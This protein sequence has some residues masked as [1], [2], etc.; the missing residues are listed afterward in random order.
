MTFLTI[1][2]LRF[3]VVARSG[4]RLDGYQAGERLRDAF[5]Q[6]MLQTVCP[7]THPARLPSPEHAA[8]CPVCWLLAYHGQSETYKTDHQNLEDIAGEVRR[9]YS[10]VPPLPPKQF[11]K[12]GEQFSFELN[13][14]G[15]GDQYLP[16]FILAASEA[17]RRGIGP[18]RGRFD[19]EAIWALPNGDNEPLEPV[20]APGEKLI[21]PPQN[22]FDWAEV[23]RIKERYT[24]ALAQSRTLE[25]QFLTP[26]RL[27]FDGVLVKT[28]DFGVFFRRL[29][30]RIDHLG[31]QHAFVA[32][33]LDDDIEKLYTL[34]DQVR[35]LE[36]SIQWVD[37]WG[38]S[39]RTGGRTPM[40][41][42]VGTAIYHCSNWE[43]LLPWL[44][45]GQVVQ[46]GKLTSKG[47]GVFRLG[48]PK[49]LS[50]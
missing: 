41:G 30:E 48:K 44:I 42:F 11:I 46:V 49:L 10:I 7:E 31:Q 6:V 38:P 45:M 8:V 27:V 4:I 21:R 19:I 14:F 12:D 28:P 40:G 35:N 43:P 32:R 47:N 1:L 17:G 34:A 20:L 33:R 26:T 18:G 23:Q 2:R 13:L 22:R 29:L 3:D 37:L 15:A 9:I 16:Y 25:I 39:G 36:S 50:A 24:S 5:A